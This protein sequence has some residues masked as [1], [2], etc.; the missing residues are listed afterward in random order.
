MKLLKPI[1]I[2][3]GIIVF[4]LAPAS[5]DIF[6]AYDLQ[7]R[8]KVQQKANCDQV[9]LRANFGKW[10]GYKGCHAS[11]LK[12]VTADGQVFA[13]GL[14]DSVC[15]VSWT[16]EGIIGASSEYSYYDIPTFKIDGKN[17]RKASRYRDGI[18]VEC[19]VPIRWREST[20]LYS[21]ELV[22]VPANP[23]DPTCFN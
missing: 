13:Q 4:F 17:L 14:G 2:L 1:F 6:D 20:A 21:K 10:C 22:P 19:F 3:Q 7:N 18:E 11:V 12:Y 8:Q 23:P 5:A 16:K 15:P 9:I